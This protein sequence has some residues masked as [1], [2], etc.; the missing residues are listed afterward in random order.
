M[1][2]ESQEDIKKISVYFDNMD[3]IFNNEFGNEVSCFSGNL[4]P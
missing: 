2:S 4:S 3:L 1:P